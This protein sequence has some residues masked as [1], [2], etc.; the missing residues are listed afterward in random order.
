MYGPC[1]KYLLELERFY[2]AI[3][4]S[5]FCAFIKYHPGLDDL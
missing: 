3:G 4:F 1:L 2:F 5:T